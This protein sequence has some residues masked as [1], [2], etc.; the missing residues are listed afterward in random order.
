MLRIEGDR[1]AKSKAMLLKHGCGRDAGV[2]GG[3][4]RPSAGKFD[5]MRARQM[6]PVKADHE[7]EIEHH[8]AAAYGHAAARRQ[9]PS[10][11]FFPG[12]APRVPPPT[13]RA[14]LDPR[15]LTRNDKTQAAV[16]IG[17]EL[18]AATREY[19]KVR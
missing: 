6:K 14:P 12:D 18:V 16:G 4:D 15:R 1:F 2:A 7:E 10:R 11:C 13:V 5:P 8:L 3:K 9:H 19:D 17:L